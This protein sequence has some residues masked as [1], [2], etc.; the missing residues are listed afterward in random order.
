MLILFTHFCAV[1]KYLLM[2]MDYLFDLHCIV[3]TEQLL[4]RLH[5]TSKADTLLLNNLIL[6][7]TKQQMTISL[8]FMRTS[9]LTWLLASNM[10]EFWG[11][12]WKSYFYLQFAS[13]ICITLHYQSAICIF[14][15]PFLG[16]ITNV[17]E[18][19]LTI[20][21]CNTLSDHLLRM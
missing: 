6:C 19:P 12:S 17:I 5:V 21:D 20:W 2:D 1:C 11:S 13:S 10:L 14:Y 4:S 18:L 15:W 3:N 8:W 16:L 7:L 9:A